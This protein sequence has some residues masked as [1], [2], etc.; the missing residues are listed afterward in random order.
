LFLKRGLDIIQVIK[1]DRDCGDTMAKLKKAQMAE[2][3]KKMGEL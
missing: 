2:L 1:T 3:I